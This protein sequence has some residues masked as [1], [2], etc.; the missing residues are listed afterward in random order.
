MKKLLIISF[1]L[2]LTSCSKSF[3]DRNSL[4]QLGEA[5]FWKTEQDAILGINGVYDVL[6]DRI[7][8]SGNLNGN[9][10]LPMYDCFGDNAYNSF[11]FEGPGNFMA[12]NI[13]PSNGFFSA[14]WTSLYKGVARANVAIENIEKNIVERG[15]AEGWIKPQQN[16]ARHAV[17][18]LGVVGV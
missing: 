18:D 16:V 3:L 15:F 10:G 13:D 7:L 9:A 12:A 6:Q 1:V 14:L 4:T 8:Y 5:N 17:G 11:K 2:V